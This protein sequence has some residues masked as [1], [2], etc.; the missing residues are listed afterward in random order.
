[1]NT[2]LLKYAVEVEK[3]GS[4]TQA[5]GNLLMDQPNLSKAIKTLE[6]SMGA[7]I[8]KRTP[9]GVVPTD[10]GKVF[11]EYARRILSQIDEME[12]LYRPVSNNQV[13][14]SIS[15]PRA[16]YISYAF[17]KFIKQIGKAEGMNIW[18]RETNTMETIRDVESGEYRLGM[19]RFQSFFEKHYMQMLLEKGIEAVPVWDYE[20]LLL[21][22][23]HHPLA[24]KKEI[25]YHNLSQY[26][27]IMHG[28]IT[29]P[30]KLVIGKDKQPGKGCAENRIYIY[31]RGSQFDL[32]CEDTETYMWVS[33]LPTEILERHGLVQRTCGRPYQRYQDVL[34]YGKGYQMLDRDHEFLNILDEVIEKLCHNQYC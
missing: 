29:M 18:L 1:M 30:S 13:E 6:E 25:S 7:P 22:S 23:K 3:T 27:E 8:F 21:L 4:I 33:P 15:I 28:D 14:F 9:K 17:S 20:C 26:I 5:A 16:S 11:L 24:K 2:A 32:L 19:I 34:I 10:K 12:A 31:E